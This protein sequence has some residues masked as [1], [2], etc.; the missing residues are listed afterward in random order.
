VRFAGPRAFLFAIAAVVVLETLVIAPRPA[1]GML[2]GAS[3]WAAAPGVFLVAAVLRVPPLTAHVGWLIGPAV[4]LGFSVFGMLL[5]WAAGL[6]SWFTPLLGPAL[7]WALVG[8][9]R[10]MG[11]I[12]LRVPALDRRDITAIA[13]A[14]AVVPIITW[15]P[16]AHVREPVAEGEAY[17]AYFTADFIWAMT[18]T[19]ELAKGEIPP[20]NPFLR[21]GG[22][23]LHY[24]WLAHFLSGVLYKNAAPLGVT[25]EQVI[26]IDG[27]SFGLAFVAFLYGLARIAGASAAWA[28]VAVIVGFGANSYEGFNRIWVLL[29]QGASLEALKDYNIDAV[30]RWFY[31]GMPVD[32]LQRL[33]LYQPHHL[34]GYVMGLA[35]LWLVGFAEDATQV[36]VALPAGIL[37]ALAFLFST[38]TAIILGA[39][40]GLLYAFRL[41]Q[42]RAW[43]AVIPCAIL[44]GGTAAIGALLTRVLGYT[45]PQAGNLIQVGLNPVATRSWPFMLLLSFGPLLILGTLGLF[46]AG[47]VRRE[48][49]AATALVI[50][51]FAFYFLTD[52]PDMEGVWVGWRSGHQL[53]IGFSVI[54]GALLT[55]CWRERWLRWPIAAGLV[56]LC[57]LAIPTVAIDVYNAQDV[58]NR[59]QGPSFPWT[60]VITAPE[61][62]A[63]E[64]VKRRTP[65][66]A[67]VQVEPIARGNGH[68]AYVPAFA[69]RRMA[70]GLPGAMI[71][72]RKFE[73][74]SET[75]QLGIFKATSARDAHTMA[76]ALGIEYLL[77]GDVERRAYRGAID[78]IAAHPEY[79]PEAFKN[80]AVTIYAVAP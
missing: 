47:W 40:V 35:A 73:E 49:A 6:Q 54:T 44:G 10:W 14:L 66:T 42:A 36:A 59:N 74:A 58:S 75:V 41:L 34:T 5:L 53:L 56:V 26:L 25:A 64:W 37:L 48:G 11:G 12:S 78:E 4:G 57:V 65:P 32:G 19:G 18:V 76:A 80:D 33:L 38:F 9:W 79:F 77:V 60:L 15:A 62:E 45:D 8:I 69:E 43:Q 3:L 30:T 2:L 13:I 72:F 55:A 17:R 16:Y 22:E 31:R 24:Y 52:V 71:P 23:T 68:W 67:V 28:A 7:T 27:L 1:A 21:G 46:R 51:A 63:L 29:Q 61:R 50:A 70:A 20:V 39:A